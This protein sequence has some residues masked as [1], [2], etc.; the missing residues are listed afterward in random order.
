MSAPNSAN[1]EHRHA[2]KSDICALDPRGGAT[3]KLVAHLNGVQGVAGS[4]PAVPTGW[5]KPH[6][7][8]SVWGFFIPQR[9]PVRASGA[10]RLPERVRPLGRGQ[11]RSGFAVILK[12]CTAATRVSQFS[13][14]RIQLPPTDLAR[15]SAPRRHPASAPPEGSRVSSPRPLA[16]L[17]GSGGS[18]LRGAS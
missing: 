16:V 4:N 13:F 11:L 5:I 8:G 15:D 18:R 2:A 3:T 6:T 17:C 14:A 12:R 7:G 1:S 10:F 9:P